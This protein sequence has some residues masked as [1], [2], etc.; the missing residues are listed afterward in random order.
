VPNEW[1]HFAYDSSDVEKLLKTCW[2]ER[3]LAQAL[4]NDL[5]TL[6]WHIK[7]LEYRQ[8]P[9]QTTFKK[10]VSLFEYVATPLEAPSKGEEHFEDMHKSLARIHRSYDSQLEALRTD[11]DTQSARIRELETEI[12]I[13]KTKVDAQNARIRELETEIEIQYTK[14]DAQS[15]RIRE[16]DTTCAS[17]QARIQGLETTVAQVKAKIADIHNMFS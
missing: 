1:E 12:E 5:A 4:T 3:L 11:M 14:V 9:P 6:D 16:L 10:Y 8:V 15:A 2:K 7:P 13:Q 17:Q